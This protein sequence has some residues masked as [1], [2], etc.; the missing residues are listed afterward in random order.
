MC[1]T[2]GSVDEVGGLL[3][4]P[5]DEACD[6]LLGEVGDLI[7]THRHLPVLPSALVWD[8]I[9]DLVASSADVM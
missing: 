7:A 9:V 4:K 3:S 2:C 5:I 1:A 8:V 6:A